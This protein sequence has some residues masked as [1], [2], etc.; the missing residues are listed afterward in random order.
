MKNIP[1]TLFFFM[2]KQNLFLRRKIE[3]QNLK[4]I[5]KKKIIFKIKFENIFKNLL[6]SIWLLFFILRNKYH[7]ICQ[8]YF[9]KSLHNEINSKI[10]WKIFLEMNKKIQLGGPYSGKEHKGGS[11]C[12][13]DSCNFFLGSFQEAS[14]LQLTYNKAECNCSRVFRQISHGFKCSVPYTRGQMPRSIA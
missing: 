1:K 8:K 5:F 11:D 9:E 13:V 6:E 12:F 3:D 14:C 4:Y 10:I 7:N 2:M